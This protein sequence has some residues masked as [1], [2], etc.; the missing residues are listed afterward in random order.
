M[1]LFY[2]LQTAPSWPS[3][4]TI[5]GWLV[6]AAVAL[7]YL[8]SGVL[9]RLSSGRKELLEIGDKKYANLQK[10]KDQADFKI[11]TLEET[12]LRLEKEKSE[13]EKDKLMLLREHHQLLEISVTDLQTL[14]NSAKRIE[15]LEDEL[16]MLRGVPK[17]Q[18][19]S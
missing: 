2:F 18:N 5:I 19:E 11:K 16:K 7:V 6:A 15:Q 17:E 3:G 12:I 9:E 13:I 10:D 8:F 4:W 14:K 1:L